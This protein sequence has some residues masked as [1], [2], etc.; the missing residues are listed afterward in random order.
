MNY[1]DPP[2]DAII[3]PKHQSKHLANIPKIIND[4]GTSLWISFSKYQ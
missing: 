3:N 4:G 1:G 2:P